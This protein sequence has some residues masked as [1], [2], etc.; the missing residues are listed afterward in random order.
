MHRNFL[1]YALPFLNIGYVIRRTNFHKKF[2]KQVVINLL[3]ISFSLL[4]IDSLISY[5]YLTGDEILNMNLSFL[6]LGPVMLIS[7]FTFKIKSNLNSKLLS[8]Y[9][10]AIY[11]V[12]PLILFLI[13]NV[14]PLSPTNLTF[15]TIVGSVIASYI[16]IQLNSKLKYIL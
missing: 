8:S 2:S 11:L 14:V 1:W 7:A 16:L 4:I 15:A 5:Y 3:I 13:I 6:V 12:H 10:I 9:S